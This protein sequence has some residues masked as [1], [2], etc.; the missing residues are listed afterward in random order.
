[1]YKKLLTSRKN[2]DIIRKKGWFK[3]INKKM[4]DK[5]SAY[6]KPYLKL[7]YFVFNGD[8]A[9]VSKLTSEDAGVDDDETNSQGGGPILPPFSR[10]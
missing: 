6:E 3:M 7:R 2:C 9:T 8:I 10:P 5:E 1:M 4:E